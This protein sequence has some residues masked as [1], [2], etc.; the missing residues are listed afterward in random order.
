MTMS[1]N[2]INR[3]KMLRQEIAAEIS[4]RDSNRRAW[5]AVY[6]PIEYKPETVIRDR[7]ENTYLLKKFE[8]PK[9]LV[10]EYFGQNDVYSLQQAELASL[11]EVE[12]VLSQWNIDSSILTA[13]WNCD[14]PL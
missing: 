1:V 8:I 10:H 13:P 14:Y 2:A 9:E 5:V 12:K 4:T 7:K 3:L 6:P 11:E